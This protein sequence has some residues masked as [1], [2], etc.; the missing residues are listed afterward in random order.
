MLARTVPQSSMIYLA[1]GVEPSDSF[2]GKLDEFALFSRALTARQCSELYRVSD[3]SP[4]RRPQRP[5]GLNEKR[6]DDLSRRQY[7]EQIRQSNPVAYWRLHD[8]NSRSARDVVGNSNGV[9]EPNSLPREPGSSTK[10][11][12]GGRVRAE[13]LNLGSTY[14]VELWFRNELPVTARPVTGYMFTRGIDGAN[15]AP[16][17]CL[18]I[19]GTHSWTGRLFVFNGNARN[20]AVSGTTLLATNSWHHVAMVREDDSLK[21]YLNGEPEIEG[22]LPITYPNG[23]DQLQIGGRNDNF[24]N[25]HGMI[26]E[27]AV[28][29]RALPSSEIKSHFKA[30]GA[31]AA[32]DSNAKRRGNP[33]PIS[34]EASL[35]RIHV[36]AG[37]E[38]Q[39]VASEPMVKDP[40]AIDW[41]HDGKLWVVEM[42]DYPLGI[43]GNGK[44]GG[45]IRY[46]IDNNEDGQYDES[47]LFADGLSF[48]TGVLVWGKGI[49]VTA[50]PEILYLEDTTGDGTADVRQTLFSGF[51]QGNQQL[52]VNGLRL[53]LDGW[54]YCASGSHHS[55]YGKASQIQST[56]TGQSIP[57]G[58]RD[59][60]IRP[61][62]GEIEAQ[63]GPSQYGRNRDDWGNWFG[64]QNSLPLWHYVLAD[65]DIRRNPHFAPPDPKRQIVTPVNPPVFPLAELQKR[66]HSF[67]QSGRF[68]SACS[69]MIYR[70]DLL[71]ERVAGQQHAFTCE[72]FH[73]L[74]QHNIIFDQGVS[75]L[76]RRD[77]AESELDF[78]A[79]RDRWC[80]PVMVR[81]GP[82][83]A[84]WVVNMYR[85]M[86]EHPEWLPESGKNELLPYYRSGEDQGRI[87]RVVPE[88]K[89]E[90]TRPV[91]LAALSTPELVGKLASTSGWQ[92]DAAQQRLI[93]NRDPATVG[94]L[95]RLAASSTNP[96]ARLHAIATL[97]ELGDLPNEILESALADQ[98]P[99][100]R[101]Q[102]VRLCANRTIDVAKLAALADDTDAKVRLQLAV[103]LGSQ[104]GSIAAQTLAKIA[105]ETADDPY[106]RANVISSLHAQNIAAV[107]SAYRDQLERADPVSQHQRE[108]QIQLFR[109]VAAIG[110]AVAIGQTI[111][112]ICSQSSNTVEAWQRVGLAE[113][114]DGL[115]GREFS[116]REL[117]TRHRELIDRALAEARL[118]DSEPS[119]VRLLLRQKQHHDTDVNRL[120]GRLAPQASVETQLAAINRLSESS[121]PAIADKLLSG[122]RSY[123]PVLR[124]QTLAVLA[125]RAEWS[126]VLMN[127]AKNGSVAIA[128]IT[129]AMR[130]RFLTTP[131][132]SLRAGWQ[133]VFATKRSENRQ[134][135]L[136]DFRSALQLTGDANRGEKVF[137]K[138]CAACHRLGSV[139][140]DVG[141]D[142]ASITDKRPEALLSA[143]LD[144]SAAVEAR[145]LT[146]VLLTVDGKALNGL[147]A[148]ETASG[149]SLLDA[150]GKRTTVLRNEIQ[151]LRSTE[152]SFMPDGLEK[153][154]SRQEIADVIARLRQ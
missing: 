146:Y 32:K 86:I 16:G 78:F 135:V 51:L 36:R 59:F 87:Y 29:N 55:G 99:G 100:V 62:T 70:D 7:E 23:C 17:D 114:L 53:G 144:P 111:E 19:G 43:D 143:I 89:T 35:E 54:V 15:D 128:E 115:A 98:H 88:G 152:K 20:D 81:T 13:G 8:A 123:G 4:P 107:V 96:R 131:D 130:Q 140:H 149:V 41:G 33:E 22:K 137:E 72:P 42:A 120:I 109:Q 134:Q 84:L 6:S 56:I 153:S 27:V 106:I 67:E 76:F 49:L 24:A 93:R 40:V 66:F 150:D 44:P 97:A 60:R 21:L 39:L 2:D 118:T 129:P 148:S 101:R 102:A 82:D 9:Y 3:M 104:H 124:S 119:A 11:F 10:N 5:I 77:P 65:Q 94:L 139:G 117:S 1:G 61:D 113:L 28:F 47:I 110:D 154:I 71:F 50:A 57:I 31:K 58:S 18:G 121:D 37:Y 142:L 103:T 48:P 14:S 75:F 108:L 73:N 68:T 91:H 151:D 141:P 105:A 92:R 80:R 133:E 45:R 122:W 12:F 126:R 30:G 52:R 64:V 136:D 145:Y 90:S 26:D 95:C 69:A 46:L 74:V 83:G 138:H 112:C 116:D 85:Y 127:A 63:S 25:F 38:V 79:S 147:L 125:S 34:P 132:Q